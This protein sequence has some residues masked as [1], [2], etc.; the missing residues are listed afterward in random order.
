MKIMDEY[1]G[2]VSTWYCTSKSML[3]EG[4]KKLEI[5]KEDSNKLAASNLHEL[6]RCWENY[7][8]LWAAE[9]HARHILFREETRYPGYYYRND[10][11]KIDDKNWKC[12]TNSKIDPNTGKWEHFKKDYVKIVD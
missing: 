5:L 6:L 3:E 8:R 12:F 2:G 9:A 10:F 4:L 1:V 7:H 11:L